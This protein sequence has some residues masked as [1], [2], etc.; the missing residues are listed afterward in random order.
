MLRRVFSDIL[1]T[2]TFLVKE[3]T[4][5]G[6]GSDALGFSIKPGRIEGYLI[7][8]LCYVSKFCQPPNIY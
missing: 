3:F 5:I 6:V 7:K 8:H 1:L 4:R 2:D